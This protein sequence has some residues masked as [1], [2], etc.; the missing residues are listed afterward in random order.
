MAHLLTRDTAQ[1]AALHGL[2][3]SLTDAARCALPCFHEKAGFNTQGLGCEFMAQ[4]R[5]DQH[6]REDQV[7]DSRAVDF[8]RLQ[9]LGMCVLYEALFSNASEA[10]TNTTCPIA[11]GSIAR[12]LGKLSQLSQVSTKLSAAQL[13]CSPSSYCKAS[14]ALHCN[15]SKCRLQA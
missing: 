4:G 6:R 12:V 2:D 9:H 7:E 14:C 3:S 11:C 1:L 15:V 8:A 5:R 10:A 13:Y